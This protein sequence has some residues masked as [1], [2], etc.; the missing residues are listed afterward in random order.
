M[1]LATGPFRMEFMVQRRGEANLSVENSVDE[2]PESI[3]PFERVG[4]LTI[5]KQVFNTPERDAYCENQSYNPWH[6]LEAHR[7]LGMISRAR[8]AV[9]KAISDL[10]HDMN[11]TKIPIG[12]PDE[13]H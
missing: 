11:N 13:A 2:W 7:P 3:A 8:S 6:S 1:T 12:L 10:R 4:V 9:Y 5:H